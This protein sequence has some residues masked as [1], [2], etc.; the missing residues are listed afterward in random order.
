MTIVDFELSH[1]TGS[2]ENDPE[3]ESQNIIL[4][5]NS[6]ETI[7][8]DRLALAALTTEAQRLITSGIEPAIVHK[9]LYRAG[10]HMACRDEAHYH[11]FVQSVHDE[12]TSV[13]T[14]LCEDRLGQ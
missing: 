11:E 3:D 5:F 1:K 6:L 2:T 10:M 7:S 4:S 12:L 9:A 8:D 14:S 13:G